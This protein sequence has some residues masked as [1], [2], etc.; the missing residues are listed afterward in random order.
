[1]TQDVGEPLGFLEQIPPRD[2]EIVLLAPIYF[3]QIIQ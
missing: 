2:K 3:Y 1:M